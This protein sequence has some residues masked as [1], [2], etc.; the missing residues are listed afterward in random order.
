MRNL[1]LESEDVRGADHALK[2]GG[3]AILA[4]RLRPYVIADGN[5]KARRGTLKDAVAKLSWLAESF[6]PLWPGRI[7]GRLGLARRS[8]RV[9][10]SPGYRWLQGTSRSTLL[11]APGE[12]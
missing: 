4:K 8:S 1:Y 10:L 11:R 12:I 5:Q 9:R 2:I 3:A 7:R 6:E